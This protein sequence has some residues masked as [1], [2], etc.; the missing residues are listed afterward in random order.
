MTFVGS[1][2]RAGCAPWRLASVPIVRRHRFDS[3]VR[4]QAILRPLVGIGLQPFGG[5]GSALSA[6]PF[7]GRAPQTP[8][9]GA[10]AQRPPSGLSQ[11]LGAPAN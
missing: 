10:A 3:V 2:D 11:R 8:T 1:A 7:S 9:G 6:Q 5:R 4:R